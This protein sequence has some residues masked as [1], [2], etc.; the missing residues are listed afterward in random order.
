MFD[1]LLGLLLC[2]LW[3]CVWHPCNYMTICSRIAFKTGIGAW[4]WFVQFL[5]TEPYF[6]WVYF[7]PWLHHFQ[8]KLRIRWFDVAGFLSQFYFLP[9]AFLDMHSLIEWQ[10]K[11][12]YTRSELFTCAKTCLG[13]STAV[14][15]FGGIYQLVTFDLQLDGSESLVFSFRF[16]VRHGVW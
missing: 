11:D 14:N 9:Y 8:W 12:W 5:I 1:V 16:F 6:R 3:C 4:Q 10:F 7:Q 15:I 2:T 13:Y